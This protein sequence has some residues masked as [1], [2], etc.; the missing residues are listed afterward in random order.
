MDLLSDMPLQTKQMDLLDFPVETDRR[1]RTDLSY[2]ISSII[3]VCALQ[4]MENLSCIH[5]RSGV[6]IDAVAA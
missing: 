3:T 2:Y 6:S 5:M 4:G 1:W